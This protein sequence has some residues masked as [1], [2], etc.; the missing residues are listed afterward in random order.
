M[1]FWLKFLNSI[2]S[3]NYQFLNNCFSADRGI[4]MTWG[5]GEHGCLGHGNTND[6]S[7]ASVVEDLVGCTVTTIS[8]GTAHVMALTSE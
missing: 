7:K 2:C 1:N 5:S 4:I 3:N 6:V 8:C